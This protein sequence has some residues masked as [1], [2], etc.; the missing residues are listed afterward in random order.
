MTFDV[1]ERDGRYAGTAV[2]SLDPYAYVDPVVRDGEFWAIVTD[3][4]DVQYVVRGQLREWPVEA[5]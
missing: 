1:Y 4:F 2:T 3:E 5:R